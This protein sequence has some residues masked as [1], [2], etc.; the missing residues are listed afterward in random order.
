MADTES[1]SCRESGGRAYRYRPASFRRWRV[2]K[3][4][5]HRL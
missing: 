1:A 4:D 2:S 3:S 5:R